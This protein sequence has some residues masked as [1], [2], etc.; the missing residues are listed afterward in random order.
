[1]SHKHLITC[2]L[3]W[4]LFLMVSGVTAN[5][6]CEVTVNVPTKPWSIRMNIPRDYGL[7]DL[8]DPRSPASRI[9]S[10]LMRAQ[11]PTGDVLTLM[12]ME[13]PSHATCESVVERYLSELTK[14]K[15]L[16]PKTLNSSIQPHYVLYT[17][18]D[19]YGLRKYWFAIF[20]Y[21]DNC[22]Y[23]TISKPQDRWDDHREAVAIIDSLIFIK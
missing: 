9:T 14:V 18:I 11:W 7:S 2:C 3:I 1:M 20:T 15:G 12:R 23:L 5:D 17:Y 8:S 6:I 19:S 21:A 16:D 22:I 4:L 10:M 13:P